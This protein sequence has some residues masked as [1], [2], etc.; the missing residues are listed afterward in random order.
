MRIQLAWI[1]TPSRL[2]A[3]VLP[4]NLTFDLGR[5]IEAQAAE[6]PEKHHLFDGFSRKINRIRHLST[7][8]EA[9]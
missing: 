9:G 5:A 6:A 1:L 8:D 7:N 4:K 2:S 3:F